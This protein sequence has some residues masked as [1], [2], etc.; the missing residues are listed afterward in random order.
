MLLCLPE[1][2]VSS[3]ANVIEQMDKMNI[4]L[5]PKRIVGRLPRMLVTLAFVQMQ[6]WPL[7]DA[8][9]SK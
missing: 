2:P 1:L 5:F 8:R 4:N 3:E 6:N 7:A 9:I